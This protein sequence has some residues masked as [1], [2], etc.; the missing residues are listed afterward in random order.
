MAG[1]H[2]VAEAGGDQQVGLDQALLEQPAWA[3]LAAELFVVGEV[4]LDA[5]LERQP[6]RFECPRGEGEGREVAFADGGGAAEELAIDHLAAIGVVGPAFAGRHHVAVRVQPDRAAGAVAAP[7][8]Q[9]GDG[10]QAGGLHVAGG[11]GVLLGLEAEGLEQFGGAVGV[12]CVVAGRRVG[13]HLH[14]LLQKAHFFVE[15]GID[16]GVQR[17]VSCGGHVG[18]VAS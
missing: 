8:D 1:D 14:Q 10:R 3:E 4:Q 7:D 15:V 13:G 11:H 9:V 5:A 6:Q 2:L 18:S 12:R 17:G 16:P